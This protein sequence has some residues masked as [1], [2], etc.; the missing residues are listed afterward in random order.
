MAGCRG[1]SGARSGP[2]H[3]FWLN[4]F[5]IQLERW[6]ILLL[7]R[8]CGERSMHS[9]CAGGTMGAGLARGPYST[10][11]TVVGE[12]VW[13]EPRSHQQ[14]DPATPGL[15]SSRG[16][17]LSN[18]GGTETAKLLKAVLGHLASAGS[19]CSSGR[20]PFFPFPIQLLALW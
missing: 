7:C 14:P 9:T 12:G 5:I 2:G 20:L 11:S 1:G 16:W 10:S 13:S 3:N 15:C 6:R 17:G 4:F 8:M 18:P 19:F